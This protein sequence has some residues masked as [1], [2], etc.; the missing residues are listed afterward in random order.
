MTKEL[1][2]RHRKALNGVLWPG[3]PVGSSGRVSCEQY[4]SCCG[5]TGGVVPPHPGEVPPANL[6]SR[7]LLRQVAESL[8]SR[9]HWGL[10]LGSARACSLFLS[11]M[12]TRSSFSAISG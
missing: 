12:T 8:F 3:L 2:T 7:S 1:S 11:R 10:S 4:V 9:L 5:H 6:A